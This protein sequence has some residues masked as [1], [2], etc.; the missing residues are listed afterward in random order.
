MKMLAPCGFHGAVAAGE[1]LDAPGGIHKFMFSREE[2]VAR[3]ANTDG[4]VSTSGTGM[5]SRSAC[6]GDDG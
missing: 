6:A 4:Q 1:F 5:V 3:R 2:R